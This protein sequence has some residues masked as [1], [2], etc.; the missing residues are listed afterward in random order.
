MWDVFGYFL[1][2][3]IGQACNMCWPDIDVNEG[4]LTKMFDCCLQ[5]LSNGCTQKE[6]FSTAAPFVSSPKEHAMFSELCSW[7]FSTAG[8]L[9]NLYP[10]LLPQYAA[11]GDHYDIQRIEPSAVECKYWPGFWVFT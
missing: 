1:K 4:E 3:Q 10:N 2:H 9:S 11:E 5:N 6:I 7:M 8:V